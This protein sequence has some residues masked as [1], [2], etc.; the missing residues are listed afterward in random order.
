M[1]PRASKHSVVAMHAGGEAFDVDVRGHTVRTDQPVASGGADAG[2]TPLELISAGLASCVALY[3]HRACVRKGL[4][5]EG[6]AVEVN[7]L[8][9]PAT[10]SIGRF[11]VVLHL[12]GSVPEDAY[13]ALE[14]AA[15]SCPVDR[16]LVSGP[17]IV[18][19]T[20]SRPTQLARLEAA[21]PMAG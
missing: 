21:V 9:K 19:S 2:P 15:S 8:W 13:P 7:P 12:P 4:D 16:T 20:V 18:V 14:E 10:A 5:A 6:L 11:D 1:M 3:V 17:E